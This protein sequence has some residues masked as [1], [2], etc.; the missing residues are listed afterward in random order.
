MK[1]LKTFAILITATILFAIQ[2]TN[3]SSSFL[4]VETNNNTNTSN[5][6]VITNI[7]YIDAYKAYVR[8]GEG[9]EQIEVYERPFK[10][11]TY[12]CRQKNRKKYIEQGA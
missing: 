3:A 8:S 10:N 1:N 2:T 9:N 5:C 4:K 12:E 7:H 11:W 6:G